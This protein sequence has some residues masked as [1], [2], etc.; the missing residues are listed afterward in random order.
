MATF[1]FTEV[2]VC[3]NFIILKENDASS[4]C[5]DKYYRLLKAAGKI[6]VQFP[7]V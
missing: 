2:N 4:E 6:H 5:G 7:Y 1:F 3:L